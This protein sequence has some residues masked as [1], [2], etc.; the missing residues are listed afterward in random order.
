MQCCVR[1]ITVIVVISIVK[2]AAF[3]LKCLQR[4]LKPILALINRGKYVGLTVVLPRGMFSG[5]MLLKTIKIYDEQAFQRND[6]PYFKWEHFYRTK[7]Q[8]NFLHKAFW[9]L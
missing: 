6:L 4:T 8:G 2:A 7:R 9:P 3:H 1:K 5:V